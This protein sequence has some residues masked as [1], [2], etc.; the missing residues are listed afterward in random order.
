MSVTVGL[1]ISEQTTSIRAINALYLGGLI[2]DVASAV[3]AFLSAR[4]LERLSQEERLFLENRFT[5][6][7]EARRS[8]GGVPTRIRWSFEGGRLFSTWLGFSLFSPM[9]LLVL[10][11]T[12]MVAGIHVFAWTQ[13]HI[14]VALVVTF[15]SVGVIPMVAGDFYI[16]P[17]EPRR[18]AVIE[19]LSELQGDW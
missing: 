14:A 9:P 12:C 11:V 17:S 10:G 18:R 16:G 2:L 1:S 5:R 6:Q 7:N 3:L 15:A 4:W 19:R 13:Q 8:T